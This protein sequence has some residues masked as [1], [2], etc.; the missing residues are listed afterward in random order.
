MHTAPVVRDRATGYGADVARGLQHGTGNRAGACDHDHG[1]P[2]N[3]SS[4]TPSRAI[5]LSLRE[6]M[7]W[8]RRGAPWSRSLAPR[9]HYMN[10]SRTPE[11]PKK[12]I[13]SSG[14]AIGTARRPTHERPAR[15]KEQA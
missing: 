10:T 2:M 12:R 7:G 6:K 4:E 9:H 3:A 11:D 5:R 13:S 14:K 8:K 1:S 15:S